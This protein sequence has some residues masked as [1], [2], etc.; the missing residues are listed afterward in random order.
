ALVC[1]TSNIAGHALLRTDAR[2]RVGED[3]GHPRAEGRAEP[4]A[5]RSERFQCFIPA[6]STTTSRRGADHRAASFRGAR[7]IAHRIRSIRCDTGL[8][9]V[10]APPRPRG[11]T[12]R[13]SR[14]GVTAAGQGLR[15][16]ELSTARFAARPSTTSYPAI[17]HAPP[18]PP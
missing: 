18:G 7:V 9:C 1:A 15:S 13:H 4:G 8:P 6:V 14:T 16:G 10:Q 2:L 12:R 5:L 11:P 17:A 3:Q